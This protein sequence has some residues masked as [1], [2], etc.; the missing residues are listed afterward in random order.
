MSR[1]PGGSKSSSVAGAGFNRGNLTRLQHG[2][3][4]AQTL[5]LLRELHPD[6]DEAV[7]EAIGWT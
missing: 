6:W 4:V 7:F 2:R 5:A 3:I 1:T